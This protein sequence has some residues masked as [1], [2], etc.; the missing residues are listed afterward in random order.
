MDKEY[1]RESARGLFE[2]VASCRTRQPA[3]AAADC[4]AAA[5]AD[6]EPPATE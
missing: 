5:F 6:Y 2:D 1:D 3:R 4:E